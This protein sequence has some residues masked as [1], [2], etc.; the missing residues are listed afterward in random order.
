MYPGLKC[1]THYRLKSMK[2]QGKL[3]KA[4]VQSHNQQRLHCCD[5]WT[6][7]W[8]RHRIQHR[9]TFGLKTFQDLSFRHCGCK[10]LR[11]ELL[12]RRQCE[13][14]NVLKPF[15]ETPCAV[16]SCAFASCSTMKMGFTATQQSCYQQLDLLKSIK[17][18]NDFFSLFLKI[19]PAPLFSPSLS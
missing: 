3:M 15:A 2:G 17:S 16:S 1:I 18:L 4:N 11:G 10:P 8:I 7:L 19:L 5:S 14:S 9:N 13:E 12:G 6:Q